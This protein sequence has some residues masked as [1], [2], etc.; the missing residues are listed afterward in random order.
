M[1]YR[2]ENTRIRAMEKN[3][4]ER[5]KRR[6]DIFDLVEWLPEREGLR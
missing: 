4:F 1:L 3:D 6:G 5:K 2:G